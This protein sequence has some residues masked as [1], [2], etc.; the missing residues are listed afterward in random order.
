MKNYIVPQVDKCI[1]CKNG[2]VIS[3]HLLCD[4]CWAEK[5]R[6]KRGESLEKFEL[7][8]RIKMGKKKK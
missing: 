4:K 2:R 1:V 8:N 5:A 7:R 3:H 6:I